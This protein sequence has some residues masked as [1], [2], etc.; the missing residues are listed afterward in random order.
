MLSISLAQLDQKSNSDARE[1]F[2]GCSHLWRDTR[3]ATKFEKSGPKGKRPLFRI[4]KKTKGDRND[5]G[6]AKTAG[7]QS[8]RGLHSS[9]M[10]HGVDW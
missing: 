5:D 3:I 10:L 4:Y 2:G 6:D 1:S 9:W 7:I 8:S